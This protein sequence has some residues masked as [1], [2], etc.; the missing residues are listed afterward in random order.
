[1]EIVRLTCEAEVGGERL[2]ARL[3]IPGD[4]YDDLGARQNAEHH[5]RMKLAEKIIEKF[6]PKVSAERVSGP[7]WRAV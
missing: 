7:L 2:V 3:E 6:P 1:M 4:V 5:L